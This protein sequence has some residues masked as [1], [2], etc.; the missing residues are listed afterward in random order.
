M[1][2]I[3]YRYTSNRQLAE[4]LAHDAFLKAIDKAG[5]FKGEGV[6]DAWLRRVVVN[7]VLTYIRDQKRRERIDSWIHNDNNVAHS[8]ENTVNNDSSERSDFSTQELLD[9]INSL[10]EHH[11][12]V[13]NLYVI[14]GF[15]HIQ[16]AEALGISE[17]AF[18]QS[19]KKDQTTS[20]G[21]RARQTEINDTSL[22]HE[23]HMEN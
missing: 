23:Q 5:S 10:P 1:I 8:E 13:F 7:H 21:K 20:K 17:G 22:I 11:R 6:F 2:G 19:T 15:K 4:D 16:I 18:G 3:C 9:V 12:L 14:D